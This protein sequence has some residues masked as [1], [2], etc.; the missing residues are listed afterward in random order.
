MINSVMGAGCMSAEKRKSE[1]E[2]LFYEDLLLQL[3]MCIFQ[4]LQFQFSAITFGVFNF[5]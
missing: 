4:L 1:L 5:H 3:S 2:Y